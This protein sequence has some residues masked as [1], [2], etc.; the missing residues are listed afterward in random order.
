MMATVATIESPLYQQE[1]FHSRRFRSPIVNGTYIEFLN[2][3][4]KRRVTRILKA[5]TTDLGWIVDANLFIPFGDWESNYDYITKGE[6]RHLKELVLTSKTVKILFD[7]NAYD[8]AFV[9]T[10]EQ[11]HCY[12]ALLQGIDNAYV[13]RRIEECSSSND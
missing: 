7:T 13:C 6:G 4:G 9:L 2:Q 10:P 11:L 8:L 5:H 12:G 3:D 1:P